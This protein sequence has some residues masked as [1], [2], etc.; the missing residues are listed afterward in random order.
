MVSRMLNSKFAG[1][2]DFSLIR[3]GVNAGGLL[4]GAIETTSQAVAQVVGFFIDRDLLKQAKDCARQTDLT[5]FDDMVWEALRFVPIRPDIF[6]K[7]ASDYTM[8][9]GSGTTRRVRCSPSARQRICA[10]AI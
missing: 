3:V 2:V 8:A 10:S 9:M 6:R 5:A 4:I 1:E 7:A